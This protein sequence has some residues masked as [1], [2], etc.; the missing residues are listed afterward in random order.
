MY[1]WQKIFFFEGGCA[2]LPTCVLL[3]CR[4]L[5]FHYFFPCVLLDTVYHLILIDDDFSR[6]TSA[7]LYL[8][9]SYVLLSIVW[10]WLMLSE[11]NYTLVIVLSVLCGWVPLYWRTYLLISDFSHWLY[12]PPQRHLW[13][14]WA[15]GVAVADWYVGI[16]VVLVLVAMG[17]YGCSQAAQMA[18]G[19]RKAIINNVLAGQAASKPHLKYIPDTQTH[20]YMPFCYWECRRYRTRTL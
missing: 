19:V 8:L 17:W 12:A 7:S 20:T 10:C 9:S 3:V 15:S 11:H 2:A 6:Q 1:G 16:I 5:L 14:S 13:H 18:C 4:L